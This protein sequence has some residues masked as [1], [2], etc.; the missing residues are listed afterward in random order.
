M[1]Q[2][3]SILI[4]IFLVLAIYACKSILERDISGDVVILN[5]PPDG[6]RSEDYTQTFWWEKVE[7][8][9]KYNLQI[10]SPSF[11]Y[12]KK[13]I[14]DTNLSSTQFTYTFSPD[15]F[16]W[17]V[18][19]YNSAYFTDYSLAGFVIDSTPKPQ[20]VTLTGPASIEITNKDEIKFS[21]RDEHNASSYKL[22]VV[23]A[24]GSD[25]INENLEDKSLTLPDETRGLNKI[26][27]GE[28]TWSVR[29]FNETGDGSDWAV[30][31]NLTV[32]RTPPEKPQINELGYH[33]TISNFKI[34]WKH[35]LAGGS[36]IKDSLIIYSDSTGTNV[37]YR[38][39]LAD[40]IYQKSNATEKWYRFKV[41]SVDAAENEGPWTELR[42]FYYKESS[43]K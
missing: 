6:M 5:S 27:E 12:M 10:V 4:I 37:I 33:D 8:A 26:E 17:R 11:N 39:F 20:K 36:Q 23:D 1:K 3:H 41:K 16:T 31:R 29:A 43:D 2:L 21:W 9:S 18:K 7:G 28:F 34:S 40:T 24:Y 13:L 35:P 42:W 32:D 22:H 19:A 14:V 38:E 25:I 15:S 30:Y